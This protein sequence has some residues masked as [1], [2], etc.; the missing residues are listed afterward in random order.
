MARIAQKPG[1]F[2]PVT[3]ELVNSGEWAALVAIAQFYLSD[4]RTVGNLA[5]RQAAQFIVDND[6][7]VVK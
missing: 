3:I 7:N 4:P 6:E 2:R 5:E 1:S